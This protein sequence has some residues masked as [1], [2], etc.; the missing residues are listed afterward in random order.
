VTHPNFHLPQVNIVPHP[1]RDPAGNFLF[2]CGVSGE[3]RHDV[4]VRD[5][6]VPFAPTRAAVT[7][8]HVDL[9]EPGS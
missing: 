6:V 1:P 4:V 7:T 5:S 2:P 8:V 3:V 9:V